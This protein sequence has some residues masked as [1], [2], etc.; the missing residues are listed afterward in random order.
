MKHENR[1]GMRDGE[2]ERASEILL[3]KAGGKPMAKVLP[4]M[5][6]AVFELR[7]VSV[8][9]Q[10]LTR[11]SLWN[12]MGS[13]RRRR[14]HR[15]GQDSSVTPLS[16][17]MSCSDEL[18][19]TPV[20]SLPYIQRGRSG[21]GKSF[22]MH[23]TRTLVRHASDVVALKVGWL[24]NFKMLV[25]CLL[26]LGVVWC[27]CVLRSDGSVLCESDMDIRSLDVVERGVTSSE[28]K[29]QGD[30][31]MRD[32]TQVVEAQ[33]GGRQGC[34]IRGVLFLRC[35]QERPKEVTGQSSARR[36]MA[37]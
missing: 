26:G 7:F 3:F 19:N 17:L 11:C 10:E 34:T 20:H 15:G 1:N 2:S 28:F 5:F 18:S 33:R 30:D 29:M 25:S 37:V 24:T 14:N 8:L 6:C 35:T 12:S 36:T 23:F 16:C 32:D 21:G 31:T 13:P 9:F 4:P 22:V 27:R